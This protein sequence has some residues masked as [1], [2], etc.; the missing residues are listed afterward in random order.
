M[1][2]QHGGVRNATVLQA[3]LEAT[4]TQAIEELTGV[5]RRSNHAI[6]L[7]TWALVGLTAIGAGLGLAALLMK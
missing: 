2:E 3:E 7:L 1:Y 4:V 5:V 6:V